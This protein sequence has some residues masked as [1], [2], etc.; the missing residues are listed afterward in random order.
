MVMK[1]LLCAILSMGIVHARANHLCT[2]DA[3]VHKCM[4]FHV[5][6]EW[7]VV[8]GKVCDV[9]NIRSE[10]IGRCLCL[11]VLVAQLVLPNTELAFCMRKCFVRRDSSL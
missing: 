4:N 1:S 9:V 5:C 11:V 7:F 2:K 3:R 8:V 10:A 6:A